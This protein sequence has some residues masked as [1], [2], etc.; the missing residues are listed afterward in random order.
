MSV[1]SIVCVDGDSDIHDTARTAI[2]A[3]VARRTD[4]PSARIGVATGDIELG[5]PLGLANRLA[6]LADPGQILLSEAVRRTV[7]RE[8]HELLDLGAISVGRLVD[9]VQVFELGGP[10]KRPRT[11]LAIDISPHGRIASTGQENDELDGELHAYDELVLKTALRHGGYLERISGMELLFAFSRVAE[12]VRAAIAI[13]AQ[14]ATALQHVGNLRIAVDVRE[15]QY[16]GDR[17]LS[18]AW[19][20]V[21][22]F[23]DLARY[24]QL[25]VTDA[26]VAE[27]GDASLQAL[28]LSMPTPREEI[29]FKGRFE[30]MGLHSLQLP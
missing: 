27:L 9:R 16:F 23:C 2:A 30:P 28:G 18:S 14:W 8:Q 20:V 22:R 7:A 25:A 12:A 11:A 24:R 26:V 6:V 15:M 13:E 29:R 10:R 5:D 17:W 1:A 4:A 21:E 19:T 3:A